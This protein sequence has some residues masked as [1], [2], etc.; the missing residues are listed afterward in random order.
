MKPGKS[1]IWILLNIPH[2]TKRDGREKYRCRKQVES[3][4]YSTIQRIACYA[5]VFLTGCLQFS[6]ISPPLLCHL[7]PRNWWGVFDIIFK[8]LTR[9]F[10]TFLLYASRGAAISRVFSVSPLPLSLFPLC[11]DQTGSPD[12][13]TTAFYRFRYCVLL[14]TFTLPFLLIIVNSCKI[15][16]SSAVLRLAILQSK[17]SQ[18]Q[19][20]NY[21]F[22]LYWWV[23][24]GGWLSL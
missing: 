11:S 4:L 2:S 14:L 17:T 20:I 5:F 21:F 22:A 15:P 16:D 9:P 3:V 10:F 12:F 7:C 18:L 23:V 6:S 8:A 19:N 1:C 24:E 13:S